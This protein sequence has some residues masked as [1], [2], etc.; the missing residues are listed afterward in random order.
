MSSLLILT[1]VD[2]G[3]GLDKALHAG[4][5]ISAINSEAPTGS[6]I[7]LTMN[8]GAPTVII[9]K[10]N[11]AGASLSEWQMYVNSSNGLTI[12]DETNTRDNIIADTSGVVSFPQSIAVDTISEYTLNNGVVIDDVA[13]LNNTIAV[14]TINERVATS[15]VTVDGVL[16]KDSQVST[17]TINEL[18]AGVGVTVDG[19]LLKDGGI[20]AADYRLPQTLHSIG[21]LD[22]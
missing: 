3:I 4:T 17:D 21:V 13:I 11:G 8:S 22:F 15:G 19:V 5:T 7:D 1:R 6:R 9:D 12:R 18:S 20:V 16:L 14:D 2:G 10:G